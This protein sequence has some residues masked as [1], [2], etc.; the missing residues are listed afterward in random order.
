MKLT[1]PKGL[2]VDTKE[3][4]ISLNLDLNLGK[5]KPGKYEV[6]LMIR[7]LQGINESKSFNIIKT[8]GGKAY[9]SKGVTE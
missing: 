7:D 6:V 2:I 4:I 8:N 3:P 1:I 9:I 5:L